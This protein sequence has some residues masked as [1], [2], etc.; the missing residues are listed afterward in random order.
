MN[1][2]FTPKKRAR[3]DSMTP[4][5]EKGVVGDLPITGGLCGQLRVGR[6]SLKI[7]HISA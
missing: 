6:D 4:S 7:R 5:L 1:L 3:I 2:D